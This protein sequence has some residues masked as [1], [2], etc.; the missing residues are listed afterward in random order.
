[1]GK[2]FHTDVSF[3]TLNTLI[4]YILRFSCCVILV[5]EIL[6]THN[7]APLVYNCSRDITPLWSYK[8]IIL[9]VTSGVV[10]DMSP[11]YLR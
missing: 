7:S 1:M 6:Q 5:V 10:A 3:V 9:A 4:I 8:V 2:K 11:R